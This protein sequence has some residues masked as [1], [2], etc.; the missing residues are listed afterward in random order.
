MLG[1][2]LGYARA[3]QLTLSTTASQMIKAEEDKNTTQPYVLGLRSYFVP[4]CMFIVSSTN[5]NKEFA[6]AI[7]VI[8]Q[9]QV[10]SAEDSRPPPPP[11]D[12][13]TPPPV[14]PTPEPYV[15][16]RYPKPGEVKTIPETQMYVGMHA[17]IPSEEI[18]E[19]AAKQIDQIADL[20]VTAF[21][22]CGLDARRSHKVEGTPGWPAEK[23][24]I[25]IDLGNVQM[26]K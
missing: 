14:V 18:N 2:A 1:N 17:P 5:E 13:D 3:E 4:P 21:Q 15:V 10:C 26:C 22:N 9:I 7:E 23:W 20:I 12:A 16:V 24:T 25:Y 6:K 8:A 19:R 11:R